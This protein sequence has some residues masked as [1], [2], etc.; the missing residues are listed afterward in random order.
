VEAERRQV[1]ILV[2]D[3]VA[4]TPFSERSGEEA[5]FSLMQ[6]LAK[7]M[8]DAVHERGGVVQSFT[9]DGIM[10]VFG[11]PVAYEDA[12]LRA[13]RAALA[14]LEKLKAFSN[15]LEARHG[16]RPQLRISINS[17]P[18]VVGNV[19][20]GVNAG[21]AVLGDTVN[22]AARLQSLAEPGSAVMSETTYRHVEGLVEA[23]FTGE[24][25]IKGKS[26]A[27]NTYRLDGVREHAMRFDA[28]VQRGLTRYVGRD[29]ELEKLEHGFSAIG[30]GLRV[31]DIGGE[32]GIGKSRLVHEF[33][34]QIVKKRAR[35]L[36]GSCTPDGQRTP[37][38][39]FIEIVRGAF[40]LSPGDNDAVVAR[41]L[42]EGLQ[43]LGLSSEEN[44]GLLLNLL[45]LRPPEGALGGLDGVLIGLRTRELLKRLTVTR[46]RL[47]PMILVF[48]DPHWIDSASEDLLAKIVAIDEPLQL[49]ILHT[50]RPEYS[51]PWS[52]YPRVTHLPLEPLSARETARIAE[53]RLD[54]DRLPEMLLKLIVAKAEG[55]ALFAE[56]IA[57][58]LVERSIVRVSA[59]GLEFDPARVASALPESVQSLIASRVDRLTTADRNL[60]QA[61]AVIGRRFDPALA[62]SMGGAGKN[63]ASSFAVME[64]LDLIYRVEG[65]S[66]YVFKHALVRDALYDGLLSEPRAFL[67]LKV[68]DELER[69]FSNRLTEIAEVLAHHYAAT[70]HV[71]KAFTYLALAGQKS[72]DVYSIEEAE[73]YFRKA[74]AIFEARN[75]CAERSVVSPLIVRLLQTLELKSDYRELAKVVQSFNRFIRSAGETTELVIVLY[76]EALSLLYIL[77]F[78]RAHE[79]AVEMLAIAERLG[80]GRALAYAYGQLLYTRIVLGLDPLVTAERMKSQL[81]EYS[82]EFGDPFIRNWAYW[83]VGYDYVYRGLFKEARE[84]AL[85]L[86]RALEASND[87]RALGLASQTL[88]YIDVF[89]DAPLGAMAYAEDCER[90]AVTP[91]D[92]LQGKAVKSLASIL[93]GRTREGLEA[94]DAVYSDFERLGLLYPIANGPRG[95]AFAM[96][97]EISKG[98]LLIKQQI[99]RSDALGHVAAGAWERVLLAEIY[100]E[101]LSG[102]KK[103]RVAVVLKNFWAIVDAVVFGAR[104]ARTLLHQAASVKQ[105]SERGVLVARINYDLGVLSA[106]KKK[107]DEARG[108]LEKAR[109]GAASQGEDN[110]VQRINAALAEL[111]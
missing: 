26:N 40:R 38:L 102:R 71:E 68:A 85:N 69:R 77:D 87:P 89:A 2:A 17:G 13:C 16:A 14:I 81:M 44:L 32:P 60:L 106:M 8:E 10:A 100:I 91:F 22:V 48:E 64:A 95:V 52:S 57:T 80:N 96:L 97:G 54:V 99:S 92:R 51:T 101:I 37:F 105:L 72:L 55:N 110:L 58:F 31:F 84:S 41:K 33:L 67:H 30:A 93:I 63:A 75:D 94:L 20:G 86:I 78:R 88:G 90:V 70:P 25:Q 82:R 29:R 6:S 109:V 39:A 21:V 34:G 3:M 27:V 62:T 7:L 19:Q 61:A 28:K 59:A 36:T 50:R 65:S 104:H 103:P 74:L 45:G 108:Y 53:E 43:G 11:A 56:E 18:A 5:A 46:S 76:Y 83:L 35:V 1:T 4:F 24:H 9:G 12:P 79:L 98:I 107:R 42:D 73:Q 111:Q 66:D 15:D 49:L 47:T 23:T